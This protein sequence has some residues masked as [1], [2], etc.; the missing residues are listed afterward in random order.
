MAD[1]LLFGGTS[2]GRELASFLKAKNISALVCVATEYGK[3]LLDA[4]GSVRVRTGRLDENAMA[5]LIKEIGPRLV[6]DATH[7]YAD[8]VS[9]S[10][11]AACESTGATYLRIKRESVPGDGYLTFS[12]MD[13]LIAWLNTIEG[14]IFSSLGAKEAKALT[15]VTGFESRI[16]LRILPFAEGLAACIEAGFPAQR[17]ICMQGPFS[18]ELN[19]AMFRA[20]GASILITK[21]SGA[22][23]G[24]LEK[25]SAARTCGMVVA[26]L[27]RPGGQEGLTVE[28]VKRRIEDGGL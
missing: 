14:V 4:G 6:I 27:A 20:A 10:L 7:P 22:A 12:N 23:G 25:L 2:E 16:W 28:E 15:A 18:K 17:I 13:G 26:A 3:E 9:R 8:V 24:F 11:R 19:V 21:E 1:I 5:A